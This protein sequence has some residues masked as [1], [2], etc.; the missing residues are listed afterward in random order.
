MRTNKILS[1]KIKQFRKALDL[2]Q[3]EFAAE[4]GVESQHI[5]AVERGIKGISVE[6]LMEICKKF[7]LKMDDLLPTD[8]IDTSM[9]EKWIVEI[10]DCLQEMDAVHVGVLRRMICSMKR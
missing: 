5:S 4:I 2:T 10:A 9:K 3:E 7:N 1:E 8:E 6:K